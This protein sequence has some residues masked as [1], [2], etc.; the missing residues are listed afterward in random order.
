MSD[1]AKTPVEANTPMRPT[2]DGRIHP[3]VRLAME[4]HIDPERLDK[5]L[6]VQQKWDAEQARKAFN[7]A[8][9]AFRAEVPQIERTGGVDYTTAQGRTQYKHA[10]LGYTMSVVNPLLA[11]HGLN[12]SWK[13]D[14]RDGQ[15]FV[16]CCITHADGHS[17]CTTLGAPPDTSGGKN[18]I[19]GIG[20]TVSYL[21]RYTLFALAGLASDQDDDDGQSAEIERI[22]E[23]QAEQIRAALKEVKGDEKAFCK[24]MQVGTVED[25]RASE[26]DRGLATIKRKKK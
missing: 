9:A 5:L 10:K 26:F 16:T 15:V 11:K 8:M 6:D 18:G 24:F 1:N 13:T 14:Q 21:E 23:E 17:E 12:P 3:M 7:A 25:I 2:E 19:Q 4:G 20:S 22:T